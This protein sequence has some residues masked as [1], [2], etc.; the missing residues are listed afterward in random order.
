LLNDPENKSYNNSKE[1]E[2]AFTSRAVMPHLCSIRDQINRKARQ[3]GYGLD[4]V[5]TFDLNVFPEL[6]ED[7]GIQWEYLKKLP[8]SWGEKLGMAGV[9]F[10]QSNPFYSEIWVD[11]SLQP[12]T[13]TIIPDTG[14]YGG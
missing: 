14:D 5:V 10:D 11:N 9:P 4:Y 8:L 2:K 13:D 6:Q 12:I 7:K 3:W 1:G